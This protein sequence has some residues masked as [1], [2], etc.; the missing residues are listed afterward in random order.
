[1]ESKDIRR[2][3]CNL[4]ANAFY[5]NTMLSASQIAKATNLSVVTVNAAL[6]EMCD[7]GEVHKKGPSKSKNGRPYV[8]YEYNR[9]YHS[10]AAI[11]AYNK[12]YGISL[13]L[14]VLN[15]FGDILQSESLEFAT[16]DESHITS[17]LD[18]AKADFKSI[19]T[20][21]LGFPGFESEKSIKS[22]DFSAFLNDAFVAKIKNNYN[23]DVEF[24]NDIN[25]AT[26]GHNKAANQEAQNKI[27]I[28]FPKMFAPG[29]GILINGTI[30]PGS[31]GFAGEIG[32]VPV[33]IAWN[34]LHLHSKEEIVMQITPFIA[35]MIC[36]LNPQ[37][38]IIYCEYIDDSVI[39]NIVS[40]ISNVFQSAFIPKIEL[41][42]SFCDDFKNGLIHMV[43]DKLQRSN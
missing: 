18:K 28:F 23:L 20:L 15:N 1:M 25:V 11:F 37:S 29:A 35:Q 32:V 4:I 30:Y 40:N 34:E 6:Q 21:L 36:I 2:E 41:C 26:Y 27:G 10:G 8:Q 14:L 16:I 39:E 9:S 24:V 12:N 42:N 7:N 19:K 17:L 22:C 43:K 31:S 38:I 3:N 33:K 5:D 13:N